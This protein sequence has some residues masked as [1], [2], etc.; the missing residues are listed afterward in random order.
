ME[1]VVKKTGVIML[2]KITQDHQTRLLAVTV[3]DGRFSYLLD[4]YSSYQVGVVI[5]R[6]K[7]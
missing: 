4:L 1:V 7:S 6:V 2:T 3:W 5:S